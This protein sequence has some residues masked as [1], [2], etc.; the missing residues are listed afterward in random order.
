VQVGQAACDSCRART[1]TRDELLLKLGAANKR[2]A[3][4]MD[5]RP[6]KRRRKD[7]PDTPQTFRFSLDRKKLREAR[8]REGGYLLRS[9]IAADDP[10]H[11]WSLYLHLVEIEQVFKEPYLRRLPRR[12]LDGHPQTTAEGAGSG[13]DAESS[14]RKARGDPDDRRR[15]AYDRRGAIVLSRHT[16]PEDDHR[17]MLQRLKLDLPPSRRQTLPLPSNLTRGPSHA[18][19]KSASNLSFERSREMREQ[20]SLVNE[21]QVE[22]A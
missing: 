10:G 15:T 1:L 5:C 9:N 4:P 20:P 7:E 16:E 18:A 8:R 22:T 3:K 6:S 12:R 11:L 13:P 17:L 19:V 14:S 21:K 2:R